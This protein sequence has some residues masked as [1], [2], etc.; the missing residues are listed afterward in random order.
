TT[1]EHLLLL[2]LNE[3]LHV[4]KE[5]LERRINQARLVSDLNGAPLLKRLNGASQLLNV[6]T[7]SDPG[8][9]DG[10]ELTVRDGVCVY[11]HWQHIHLCLVADQRLVEMVLTRRTAGRQASQDAPVN[12]IQPLKRGPMLQ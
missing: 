9:D 2:G 4:A 1:R 3:R 11:Q 12:S 6:R 7:R 8:T 5:V 10:I